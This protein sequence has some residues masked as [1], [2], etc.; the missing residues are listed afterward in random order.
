MKDLQKDYKDLESTIKNTNYMEVLLKKAEEEKLT[1]A[2]IEEII[3]QE[4]LVLSSQTNIISQEILMLSKEALTKEQIQSIINQEFSIWNK[5]QKAMI[6]KEY[7]K[8]IEQMNEML[9]NLKDSYLELSNQMKA[10]ELERQVNIQELEEEKLV[11]NSENSNRDNK[12]KNIIDFKA[13]KKQR[14]KKVYSIEEDIAYE[15]L[16]QTA[17][18]VIPLQTK[19]MNKKIA[20]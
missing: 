20:L 16:E 5:E 11:V 17:T 13:F 10:Q 4:I 18:Y 8:Q 12:M 1:K 2:Q 3:K 19:K 15:D 6:N 9:I 14:S 7:S